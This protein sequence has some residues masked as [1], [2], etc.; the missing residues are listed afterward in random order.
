LLAELLDSSFLS[1]LELVVTAIGSAEKRRLFDRLKSENREGVVFKQLNAPYV[2]GRPNCG[3]SQLR[4]KF[5]ATLSAVVAKTNPQRSVELRLIG[6]NGW[7]PAGNVTI[8]ANPK[9][10]S[11]GKVVEV[12]YLY[13]FPESGVLFQ[14]VY[15]GPDSTWHRC[16][17]THS[18]QCLDSKGGI[19]FGQVSRRGRCQAHQPLPSGS[20]PTPRRAQDSALPDPNS[21]SRPYTR[22]EDKLLGIMPDAEVAQRTGH[23][24]GSIRARRR[25]LHCVGC[26]SLIKTHAQRHICPFRVHAWHQACEFKANPV[27]YHANADTRL[28]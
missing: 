24:V 26:V 28:I 27:A 9:V 10:P 15:L 8:P 16:R 18:S 4:H 19:T 22:E 12:R 5:T 13:A 6:R 14:P 17:A 25:Q 1:H 7:M 21:K 11:V 20:R 23:P 3:G 2:R